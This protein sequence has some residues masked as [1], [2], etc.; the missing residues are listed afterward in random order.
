MSYSLD[1]RETSWKS[2]SPGIRRSTVAFLAILLF[3]LAGPGGSVFLRIYASRLE[4][5]AAGRR[6]E[7]ELLAVEVANLTGKAAGLDR[8]GRRLTL[9]ESLRPQKMAWQACLM[10]IF[11]AVPPA[12]RVTGFRICQ[13]GILYLSGECRS[14]QEA[15]FLRDALIGLPAYQAAELK[16][17]DPGGS[18]NRRFKIEAVLAT[19]AG[20][21]AGD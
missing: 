14:P 13:S 4:Q 12:V 6:T 7:S 21:A 20:G 11:S 19:G 2:R 8:Y 18:G 9:E 3:L 10:E 16:L 15:L 5:Q 1:L 17:I